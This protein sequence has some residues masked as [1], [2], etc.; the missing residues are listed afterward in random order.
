MIDPHP[1]F[2][3]ES[4]IPSAIG[5]VEDVLLKEKKNHSPVVSWF[6]HVLV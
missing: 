5:T 4:G 6:L 2:T 1:V 3:R